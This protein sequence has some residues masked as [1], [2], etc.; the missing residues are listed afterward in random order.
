MGSCRF[1]RTVAV[2]SRP[3]IINHDVNTI[4]AARAWENRMPTNPPINDKN[5][6]L[7]Y[8][9]TWFAAIA[10]FTVL[11]WAGVWLMQR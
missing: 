3:A 7:P 1:E 4:W 5:N 2:I 9:I 10:I 8:I 11:V 6:T